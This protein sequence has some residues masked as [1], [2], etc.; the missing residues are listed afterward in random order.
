MNIHRNDRQLETV[1]RMAARVFIAK[2]CRW[3]TLHTRINEG[4]RAR[5]EYEYEIIAYS[6]KD[7]MYIR[8]CHA[9]NPGQAFDIQR[10]IKA[11]VSSFNSTTK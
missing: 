2:D 7:Q 3:D 5:N 1:C 11:N 8:L 4:G 10:M 6:N 9:E